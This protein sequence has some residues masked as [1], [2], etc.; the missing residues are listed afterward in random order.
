[1]W[2]LEAEVSLETVSSSPGESPDFR[3]PAH[4]RRHDLWALF[5][6]P[7]AQFTHLLHGGHDTTSRD[8]CELGELLPWAVESANTQ[9]SLSPCGAVR[10][11][12][13]SP[14]LGSLMLV[15]IS[16]IE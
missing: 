9:P 1:M 15:L 8:S 3:R 14:C 4:S 10:D 16:V 2:Q 6:L 5:N 11:A 12:Q 13:A 7:E